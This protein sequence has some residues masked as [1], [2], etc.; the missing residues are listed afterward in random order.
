MPG[1]H[2]LLLQMDRGLE[3]IAPISCFISVSDWGG[4]TGFGGVAS[5]QYQNID[6]RERLRKLALE[7]IDLSKVVSLLGY[8]YVHMQA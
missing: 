6:R 5:E 3:S 4:K 8:H 7:T 2:T 1:G